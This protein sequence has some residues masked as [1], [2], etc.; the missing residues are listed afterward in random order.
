MDGQNLDNRPYG[1]IRLLQYATR[2]KP[3]RHL[4]IQKSLL[5]GNTPEAHHGPTQRDRR[6]RF[7]GTRGLP[8]GGHREYR[9]P[10]LIYGQLGSGQDARVLINVWKLEHDTHSPAQHSTTPKKQA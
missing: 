3:M 7:Q 2:A 4:T 9:P 5:S 1:S 10:N 8:T 6:Q